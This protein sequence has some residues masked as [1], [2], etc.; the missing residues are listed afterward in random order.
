MDLYI[1]TSAIIKMLNGNA[2]DRTKL[3][4]MIA[5]NG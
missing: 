5:N 1:Y 4:Q 2:G 3:K